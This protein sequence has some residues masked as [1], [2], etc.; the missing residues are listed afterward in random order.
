ML[1][2]ERERNQEVFQMQTRGTHCKELQRKIIDEEI[3]DLRRIR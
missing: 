1:E 2:E 3:E